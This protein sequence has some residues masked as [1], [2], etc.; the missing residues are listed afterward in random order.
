MTD[1]CPKLSRAQ[2]ADRVV[3]VA[4]ADMVETAAAQDTTTGTAG[5]F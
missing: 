5:H 2:T 1:P 4:K 3:T